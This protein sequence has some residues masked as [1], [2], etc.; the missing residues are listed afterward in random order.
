MNIYK[1]ICV[2]VCA[3]AYLYIHI[4]RYSCMTTSLCYV[5]LKKL[6]LHFTPRVPRPDLDN[7]LEQET[8]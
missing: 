2:C 3:H 8:I 4:F 7:R 1:Y 6:N 5:K